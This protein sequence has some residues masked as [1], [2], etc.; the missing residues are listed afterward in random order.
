MSFALDA[1]TMSLRSRLSR[2]KQSRRNIVFCRDRRGPM[3]IGPRD[4]NKIGLLRINLENVAKVILCDYILLRLYRISCLLLYAEQYWNMS[5]SLRVKR[6]SLREP[7]CHCE[8][9][10][11]ISVRSPTC[12]PAG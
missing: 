5:Y 9:S 10:E 6:R 11:A 1:K 7:R 4:D 8:C 3:A 2:E 12:L